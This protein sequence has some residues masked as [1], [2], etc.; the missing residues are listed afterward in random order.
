MELTPYKEA[1]LQND[2]A[3]QKSIKE[4]A[5][6]DDFIDRQNQFK[7]IQAEAKF[8][9]REIFFNHQQQSQK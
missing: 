8:W 5:L 6:M 9:L 3:H 7:D 2:E 1:V 4:L